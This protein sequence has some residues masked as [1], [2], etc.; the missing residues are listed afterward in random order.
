LKKRRHTD[1]ATSP[2]FYLSRKK[3]NINYRVNGAPVEKVPSGLTLT[4]T[5]WNIEIRVEI[6]VRTY[7]VDDFGFSTDE[8][9]F[10]KNP[11]F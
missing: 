8:L 4:L 5:K 9:V 10:K 2:F 11:L 6:P 7:G 1:Q 3:L